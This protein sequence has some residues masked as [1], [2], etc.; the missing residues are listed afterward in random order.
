ME[1]SAYINVLLRRIWVIVITLV[2]TLTIVTVGTFMMTPIYTAT[3][4]IRI[5]TASANSVDYTA[6]QYATLLLNTYVNIATSG[7]LLDKLSEQLGLNRASQ[8]KRRNYSQYGIN[9][10]FY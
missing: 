4:I 2:V 3:A 5:A 6:Y 1:L 9:P 7:P 10:N 8:S